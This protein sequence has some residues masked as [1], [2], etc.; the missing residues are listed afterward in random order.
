MFFLRQESVERDVGKKKNQANQTVFLLSVNIRNYFIFLFDCVMLK[1]E[2]KSVGNGTAYF[3]FV[4]KLVSF[5]ILVNLA[6]SVFFLTDRVRYH[7]VYF[8]CTLSK[9]QT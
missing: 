4:E 7:F 8:C 1:M 3:L 5:E 6:K 2:R 9:R